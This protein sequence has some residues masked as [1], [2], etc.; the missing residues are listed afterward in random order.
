MQL[1]LRKRYQVGAYATITE[2][3]DGDLD[4]RLKGMDFTCGNDLDKAVACLDVMFRDL[5][6]A[7]GYE[8]D[9]SEG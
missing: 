4:I 9:W 1:T 3:H 8:F 7:L 2:D 6:A 5:G